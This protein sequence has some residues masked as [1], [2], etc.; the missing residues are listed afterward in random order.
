VFGIAQR[1]AGSVTHSGEDITALRGH[2][3]VARGIGYVPQLENVF[4]QLTVKEN[5]Q[6]GVF[7]APD[8]WQEG[9]RY[10]TD[11][12]PVLQNLMN[13]RAGDLSGGER[14][15]V[16]LARALM[17]K[18]SILLLDEPSAGLSPIMQEQVFQ[19]IAR[20]RAEGIAVLIVE[21]NARRCLEICDRGYILDQGKNA[22]S[23]TGYALLHDPRV[24]ELYLGVRPDQA[25]QQQPNLPGAQ[26][27]THHGEINVTPV[28][29]PIPH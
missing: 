4:A 27:L 14:Q 17:L 20:I 23:G 28:A 24:E 16:A 5:L 9:L 21:Q 8:R 7:L 12:F 15:V 29:C 11:L 13:K 19:F 2:Q 18:P 25:G 3:L 10:V 6:T 1:R 26:D 22:Y